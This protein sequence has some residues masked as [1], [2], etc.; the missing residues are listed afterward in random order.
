MEFNLETIASFISLFG[1]ACGLLSRV[2]QVYKVYKSQ[3]AND[4]SS[5]TMKLNITA[6]GCFLF[7]TIV[8]RQYPIMLNCLAVVTLE[9]SLLYMKHKFG[10]IKKSSSQTSLVGMDLS[11]M[12]ELEEGEN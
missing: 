6:N 4:L 3:S 1:T 10:K 12:A 2:P 9:G 7:Y 11:A 8:H 5:N